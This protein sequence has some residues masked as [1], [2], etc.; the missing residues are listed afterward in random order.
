VCAA[1]SPALADETPRNATSGLGI[2]A[3]LGNE[4]AGFGGEVLYYAELG[5]GWRLVP[6]AGAGVLPSDD[7]T[8]GGVASILAA[9]G[10]EPAPER[11]RKR[12]WKQFL[13]N[14]WETLYACD[15][16]AVETLGVFG[17]VRYMVFFVIDVKSRE[18]HIAGVRIAPDG[19]WLT[20]LARNLVNP[21]DGFLRNATHLVHDRDP[22]F[23]KAWTDLLK[24]AGVECVKIPASSPNCNPYAER[25]V[26][27]I[28]T[29]CLDQFLILGERHLRHLLREFVVHYH[30]ERYHQGLGGRIIMP[31]RRRR[32][33]TTAR[34]VRSDAGRE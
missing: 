22:V 9:A 34:P 28:K 15:F 33:T 5:S 8:V 20:Q 2:A 24:S 10:I 23:T 30:T 1:V 25:F 32:A 12:T 17:T 14:H 7:G 4:G 3:G 13:S 6:H 26:K 16:F 31:A 11:T 21:V 19:A 18:V 27:T 29:E